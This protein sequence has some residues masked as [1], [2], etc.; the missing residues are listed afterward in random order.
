[1]RFMVIV[2]GCKGEAKPSEELR[3][4]MQEFNGEL[5]K[6]G[7]LVAIEGLYSDARGARVKFNGKDRVVVTDGPFA[8]TKELIGGFWLWK[9][10][11]KETAIE[12]IKRIPFGEGMEVE[13]RQVFE[14]DDFA[15]RFSPQLQQKEERLWRSM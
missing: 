4:A 13:L 3:A 12:W 5:E 8:E 15:A 1:M 7:V 2:K 10:P 11:S 6:A 9:C 14:T